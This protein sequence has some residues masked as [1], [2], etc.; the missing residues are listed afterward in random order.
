MTSLSKLFEDEP[1]QWGLRGDPHLWREMRDHFE[2]VPLPTTPGELENTIRD[3]FFELTGLELSSNQIV[4]VEK[5]NHG[6]M[7][8]GGISAR[9]WQ[10]TALPLLKERLA[11]L[12][13]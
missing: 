12:S 13:D 4:K 11:A 9:F 7:S 8:K 3:M 1:Q 2:E 5:Y 10:D 6:G